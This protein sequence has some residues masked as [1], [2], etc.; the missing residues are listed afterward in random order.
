MTNFPLKNYFFF[1]L[2]FPTL[3]WA[4][5]EN[6]PYAAGTIDPAETRYNI[7]HYQFD[8]HI[9]RTSKFLEGSVTLLAQAKET[10]LDSFAIELHSVLQIDTLFYNNLIIKDINRKGDIVKVKLPKVVAADSLFKMRFVYHG[11]PITKTGDWGDGTVNKTDNTFGGG[12]QIYYSLSVPYLA[13]QWF[14]AKQV[15]GDLVDSVKMNITTDASNTVASNGILKKVTNLDNGKKRFEWVTFYPINYYLISWVVGKYVEYDGVWQNGAQQVPVQNFLYNQGAVTN[16]KAILDKIPDFLTNYSNKFGAYPFA[17]EK[18]GIVQVP[19]SG[20]MEHQ[21]L[22]NLSAN[23]DKYLLAHEMSH[24]WWG[25]NVNVGTL[26]DMWLNEG[27]ASYCEY[28]TAEAFYPTEAAGKMNTYHATALGSSA[29]RVYAADT[30]D[31]TTIYNGMVYDKGAAILHT[32]RFEVNDDTKF[33]AA[34]SKYQ[35]TFS[36]KNVNVPIFKAFME[37]E[38]TMDLTSFFEQWYNGYGYPTFKASWNSTAQGLLIKSIETTSSNKTPFFK[39]HLEFK[40][41]TTGKPDTIVRVFQDENTKVFSFPTLKNATNITI[42]PNNWI[43]NKTGAITKDPNLV[44]DESPIDT[45]VAVPYP[46]PFSTELTL[47]LADNQDY[48]ISIFALDGKLLLKKS[49]VGENTIRFA[50]QHLASGTYNLVIETGGQVVTK[51]VVKL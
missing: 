11:T 9:E 42:D 51:Q 33:F 46:N 20:G 28:L 13:Q 45:F 17:K 27:F 37:K 3:L 19:L 18:F 29:G 39:T 7:H 38:W 15:L 32:L 21:T 6:T 30:S 49:V 12:N 10:A 50:T 14:P 34:L 24:Q 36:G 26:H 35:Q 1:L 8:L 4:Q 22:V 5:P 25:D 31:F 2:L 41:S 47:Q 23:F 48:T 16:K 40:V 43:V 44:G